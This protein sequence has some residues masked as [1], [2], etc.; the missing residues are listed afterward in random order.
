MIEVTKRSEH[1]HIVLFAP[2]VKIVWIEVL[3]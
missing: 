2:L 1:F 3:S